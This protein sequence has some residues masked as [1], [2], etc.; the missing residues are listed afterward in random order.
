MICLAATTAASAKPRPKAPPPSAPAPAQSA[1]VAEP[2]K[3]GTAKLANED[4]NLSTPD[5]LKRAQ[6]LYSSLEYD[7]VIPVT[8][9]LLLREDLKLEQKLEAHRLNASAKAIVQDPVDAEKPF[10]LLLRS[11]P[12]Y[13]LPGD[14]PPKILAVFRKV[15]IE[16]K[17]LAEQAEAFVRE[18]LVKSMKVLDEPATEAKGGRPVPFALRLRDP[19]AVVESVKVP[20]RRAGQG[21][22]SV[23]PLQH[24]EDGRWRGQIPADFT[25][26]PNGFT[27]EY[28]VET[29][30]GKGPLLTD[31]NAKSPRKIDIAAGKLQGAPPP[32]H[33]GIFFTGLA[34][35]VATAIAWG[36]LDIWEQRT[37]SAYSNQMGIVPGAHVQA[38]AGLGTSLATAVNVTGF[39]ALGLLVLT[40]VLIPFTDW[41]TPR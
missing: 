17:A 18:G 4:A 21:E 11:R 3:A 25:A 38:Q 31:G 35:T 14:T 30:D 41:E 37:Q 9:A 2:A 24:D 39:T 5:L 6:T 1:L 16:E 26:D 20:Y 36:G 22:F 28:Y 15:Q 12:D 29:A 13:D 19:G 33:K 27:L 10:R 40:A 23:L 7:K 32:L 8:E 34:L